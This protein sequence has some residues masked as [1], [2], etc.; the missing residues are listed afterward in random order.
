MRCRMS[1]VGCEGMA[2][3]TWPHGTFGKGHGPRRTDRGPRASALMCYVAMCNVLCAMWPTPPPNRH[4]ARTGC[5]AKRRANRWHSH[6]HFRTRATRRRI[7]P[8][9]PLPAPRVFATIS[10]HM[11]RQLLRTNSRLGKSLGTD[12]VRFLEH[13]LGSI[14]RL[15]PHVDVSNWTES[16]TTDK[17]GAVWGSNQ[18]REIRVDVSFDLGN[19]KRRGLS[20]K[21]SRKAAPSGAGRVR[22]TLNDIEHGICNEVANR[23][24]RILKAGDANASPESLR[25]LSPIFDEQIVAAFL[26]STQ[27]YGVSV[28]DV[29]HSLRTLAEQTY[30]NKAL[31][32][33]CVLEPRRARG[34]TVGSPA[35]PTEV[36][37]KKK[38]RAL[39][40]G[41]RSAYMVSSS[42]TV[43]RFVDLRN[44]EKDKSPSSNGYFPE[45]ASDLARISV[46]SR[47]GLCL[48]RAGDILV[49][50]DGQLRFTYRFGRWHYWNHNHLADLVSNLSRSQNVS[51][52]IRG[53]V[54]KA[55]YRC[56]LDVSFRRSG[57]L[58]VILR[59]RSRAKKV[60]RDGDGL[61]HPNRDSLDCTFD[62]AL[63]ATTIQGMPRPLAAELAGLDGAIVVDNTGVIVGYG[64]I[65]QPKRHGRLGATEGSRTQAAKGAS[66]FG[67]ALKIS[68]DGDIAL[69]K[70]GD[71]VFTV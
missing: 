5:P 16:V 18:R 4:G 17:N 63:P 67:V 28:G 12:G 65:L 55:V 44:E 13:A 41:F 29:L 54:A 60:L 69:Y 45:W 49:F 26:E 64:A 37:R 57:G 31:A 68:S 70:I 35:F 7:M 1:D 39:T 32:F 59:S 21:V 62:S 9:S 20:A 36:L 33:G 23:T 50:Q 2:H 48:T 58:L 46:D 52:E 56:A 25:A 8:P 43:S 51:K 22:R 47:C 3:R 15:L 14:A 6:L 10:T 42:G 27:R 61:K 53:K 71:A 66:Y 30:E 40:D 38:Y 11:P 34:P 19:G 24:A